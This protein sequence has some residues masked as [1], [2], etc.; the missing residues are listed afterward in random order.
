ME[1]GTSLDLVFSGPPPSAPEIEANDDFVAVFGWGGSSFKVYQG[2]MNLDRKSAPLPSDIF[3]QEVERA[4]VVRQDNPD[5]AAAFDL[6][7]R[8]LAS[9]DSELDSV[10]EGSGS[11]DNWRRNHVLWHTAEVASL[12]PRA[13]KSGANVHRLLWRFVAQL[14]DRVDLALEVTPSAAEELYEAAC[15]ATVDVDLFFDWL[16][17]HSVDRASMADS[18]TERPQEPEA[19]RV[20]TPPKPRQR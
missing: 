13:F 9:L 2:R 7:S 5:A 1:P 16:Q 15:Q 3:A 10:A 19:N 11:L 20:A 14:F 8:A 18:R 6:L 4:G 12:M 17:D